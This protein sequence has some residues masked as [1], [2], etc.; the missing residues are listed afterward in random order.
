MGIQGN[1]AQCGE[2]STNLRR[3]TGKCGGTVAYCS[4]DCQQKHWTGGG[5]KSQCGKITKDHTFHP[6]D[7]FLEEIA[8][9]LANCDRKDKVP[10]AYKANVCI[11]DGADVQFER[12]RLLPKA[13]IERAKIDPDFDYHLCLSIALSYKM[14]IL[15]KCGDDARCQE[16]GERATTIFQT[17]TVDWTGKYDGSV[18]PII[19][20]RDI[21]CKPCCI[22]N[23]AACLEKVKGSFASFAEA[24]AAKMPEVLKDMEQKAQRK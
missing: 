15:S 13:A 4:T 7:G 1:C 10:V 5:H 6:L 11:K 23:D 12:V 8:P 24:L 14:Q 19:T 20:I 2:S 3:C 16:C 22:A 17:P 18:D 21:W 9:Y